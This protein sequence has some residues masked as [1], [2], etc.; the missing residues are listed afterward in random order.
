MASQA[1]LPASYDGR[2]HPTVSCLSNLE[3]VF[4]VGR[5]V[6]SFTCGRLEPQAALFAA[7][8]ICWLLAWLYLFEKRGIVL[9]VVVE[10]TTV[11]VTVCF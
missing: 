2:F 6:I 5:G 7:R 10:V 8:I 1:T 3:S 9:V 4:S 11:R